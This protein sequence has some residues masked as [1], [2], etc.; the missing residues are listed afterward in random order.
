MFCWPL[1]LKRPTLSEAYLSEMVRQRTFT[2]FPAISSTMG[3]KY[4]LVWCGGW[5]KG[6]H[7]H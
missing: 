5:D 2:M 1:V 7:R 6:N 4:I 3:P